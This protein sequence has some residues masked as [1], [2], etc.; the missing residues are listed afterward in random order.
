MDFWHNLAVFKKK[1]QKEQK[2]LISMMLVK[3]KAL[4]L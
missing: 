1:S 4:Y 2:I 3:S